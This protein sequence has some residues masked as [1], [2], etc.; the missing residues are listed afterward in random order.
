MRLTGILLAAGLTLF[1][2]GEAQALP[3]VPV[4]G[5]QADTGAV[6]LVRQGCGFG[7][8][9]GYHGGCRLNRGPRGAIRGLLR[10]RP[11]HSCPRGTHR[12]RHS[13]VCRRNF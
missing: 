13:H 11:H 3:V 10:G 2:A 4:A 6:T 9:R 7:A 12:I 8:H 1:A 5:T